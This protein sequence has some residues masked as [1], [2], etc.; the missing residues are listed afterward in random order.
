MSRFNRRQFTGAAAA[1][2]AAGAWSG[3]VRAATSESPNEKLRIAFIGT[4]NQ[5]GFSIDNCRKQEIVALCDVDAANLE[6]RG[7]E[8]PKAKRYQD[9]R[10][11]LETEAPRIDA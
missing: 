9:F 4:Q 1:T 6:R 3:V 7:A 11:L 2:F 10:K 5:A 8:F